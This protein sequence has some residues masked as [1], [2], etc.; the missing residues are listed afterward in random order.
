M[1]HYLNLLSFRG[2]LVAIYVKELLVGSS[3]CLFPEPY[4]AISVT[5]KDRDIQV[6]IKSVYVVTLGTYITA[7]SRVIRRKSRSQAKPSQ[8]KTHRK[9]YVSP[10]GIIFIYSHKTTAVSSFS[11]VVPFSVLIEFSIGS[12]K[13][14]EL[15]FWIGGFELKILNCAI[16]ASL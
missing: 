14:R 4:L 1:A 16:V 7:I 11:T 10:F 3:C 2:T 13:I 9:Q 12:V 5:S 6:D 8:T 15:H